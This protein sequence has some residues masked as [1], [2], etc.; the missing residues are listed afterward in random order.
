MFIGL[1][2]KCP[3]LLSHLIE[4][5]ILWADFRKKKH[6]LHEIASSGSRFLCG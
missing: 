6:K 4:T 2:A 5:S 1:I 3:Y